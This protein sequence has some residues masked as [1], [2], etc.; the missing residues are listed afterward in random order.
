[1]PGLDGY[2]R[3]RMAIRANVFEDPEMT[4]AIGG[5]IL[6]GNDKLLKKLRIEKK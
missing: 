2:F 1:M 3:D 4:A 5:G 6:L